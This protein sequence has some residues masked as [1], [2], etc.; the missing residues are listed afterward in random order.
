MYFQSFIS[1]S[2]Q[3]PRALLY[4][5]RDF[6]H[7]RDAAGSGR[8]VTAWGARSGTAKHPVHVLR[9]M[10]ATVVLRPRS[11]TSRNQGELDEQRRTRK[12]TK[13]EREEEVREEKKS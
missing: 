7:L 3:I 4:N 2:R 1:Y 10:V 11:T 12:E 6:S 13:E 5:R 9:A 8:G